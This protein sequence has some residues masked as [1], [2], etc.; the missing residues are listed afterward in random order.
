LRDYF[1]LNNFKVVNNI[2]NLEQSNFF[3]K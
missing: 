1:K 2:E 3:K